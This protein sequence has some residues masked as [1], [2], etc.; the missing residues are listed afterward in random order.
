M[1]VY[2]L[3][4]VGLNDRQN[5]GMKWKNHIYMQKKYIIASFGSFFFNIKRA[6]GKKNIILMLGIN[7]Y[8]RITFICMGLYNIF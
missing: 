4:L 2:S 8:G 1:C 5:N 3:L 6:A 7:N